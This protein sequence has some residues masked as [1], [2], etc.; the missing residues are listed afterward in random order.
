[1]R[2]RSVTFGGTDQSKFNGYAT[3]LDDIKEVLTRI[4]RFV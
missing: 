1:M 3:A 2:F 4:A